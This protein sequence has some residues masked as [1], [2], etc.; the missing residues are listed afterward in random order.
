MAVRAGALLR[1]RLA[2]VRVLLVQVHEIGHHNALG[3]TQR[4]LDRIG[5]TLADAVADHQT[6]DDHL[7]R[8]LLLLGQLDLVGQL[9]HLAVDQ[10]AR[11]AVAAQHLQQV[12]ELALAPADHR[13][14]DLETGALRIRQQRIDHLLRGLRADQRA[15]LRTM[16]DAGAGEEQSQI[17]VDL[18]DGADRRTRVAVRGL[19]VDRHGGAQALD[20]ID[21]RLVHLPQELAG[22][23]RQR[24]HVAAL[25]LREQRVERQRGLAGTGQA[26]EHHHAVA[27]HLQVH[28]LQVVFASALDDDLQVVGQM[29]QV[30]DQRG[31][32]LSHRGLGQLVREERVAGQHPFHRYRAVLRR[33]TFRSHRSLLMPIWIGR[34]LY[35]AKDTAFGAM[36]RTVVRRRVPRHPRRATKRAVDR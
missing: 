33:R 4:G 32:V 21:I 20:E 27:R 19:L 25:A 5:Q 12:L 1:E 15:A 3:Q 28:V 14:E 24:F 11:I 30:G 23:G 7:D 34:P 8:M 6:V 31:A 35:H 13:R 16:R 10:S 2:A 26:G 36:I 22:V 18:G 9:V 29:P 17:V